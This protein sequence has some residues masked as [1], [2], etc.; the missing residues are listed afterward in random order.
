VSE[1]RDR[2]GKREDNQQGKASVSEDQAR[3]RQAAAVLAGPP[4]LASGYVAEDDRYDRG[5]KEKES[6]SAAQ[7]GYGQPVGP[8]GASSCGD[9]CILCRP[10]R[11]SPA[12]VTGA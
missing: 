2:D 4:D 10:S 12:F 5:G 11:S 9:G 6:D 8:R 3:R 1:H 7:R